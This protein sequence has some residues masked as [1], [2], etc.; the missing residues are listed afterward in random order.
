MNRITILFAL[1]VPFSFI[2]A[3]TL[4]KINDSKAI[5]QDLHSYAQDLNLSFGSHYG[6][7]LKRYYRP[8]DDD[9]A[10][11]SDLFLLGERYIN[12][13]NYFGDNKQKIEE[14]FRVELV[15]QTDQENFP[16]LYKNGITTRNTD[17]RLLPTHKP[18][19]LDFR[20][21]GGGYPF[22]YLQ[23]SMIHINTP[24]KIL[25]RSRDGEFF[26]IEAP[27]VNG[28]VQS[29]DIAFIDQDLIQK[30]KQTPL[31]TLLDDG[32]GL[33]DGEN[34]ISK[35]Y[36]GALFWKMDSGDIVVFRG[37]H[38]SIGIPISLKE[39][40]KDFAQIPLLP[41]SRNLAMIGSRL[42]GQNYGWG[43]FLQNRDCSMMVRDFFT[44]FGVFLPR[45][46]FD[47]ANDKQE[48][49]ISL[50]GKT[51]QEKKEMI[52]RY[53]V[54]FGTLLYMKGHIMLYVGLSNDE[55]A[56]FHSF[57]SIKTHNKGRFI[58]GGSFVTSL[59][60]G[61]ELEEFDHRNGTLLEKIILMRII[62]KD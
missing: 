37:D 48:E 17:C 14:S 18:F 35:G 29:R 47:Q 11:D 30:L 49:I 54:P 50:L 10:I 23:N 25:H 44:P 42:Y 16:S 12:G 7:F 53:G 46:S 58:V 22:D 59:R 33:S 41:T 15:R 61:V 26:Y 51:P 32:I 2:F 39:E 36:V 4:P 62:K 55:P 57:W 21:S 60:P 3:Y 19:F 52:K 28:W 20:S 6:E 38:R 56:I 8:W 1:C 40:Q 24:V 45:N 13:K 43:G 27:Y 34:F 5:S 9:F 31:V